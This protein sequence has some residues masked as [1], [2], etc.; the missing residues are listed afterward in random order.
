MKRYPVN[1]DGIAAAV[2]AVLDGQLVIYPTETCYGLGCDA[3]NG[4]AVRNVYRVKQRP[5]SKGLT[6]IVG[7]IEMA[8]DYCELGGTEKALCDAFMPG[9]LTLVAE[10]TAGMP[11][12][13]NQ[14]FVFRV[15][16]SEP[17]RQLAVKADRPIVATSANSSGEPSC[18]S[19]DALPQRLLDAA[20]VVLD[21]G[22]LEERPASTIVEV[23]DG[24]VRV[25][26]RGSIARDEIAKLLNP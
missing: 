6:V 9:P 18:Y 21:G 4:V 10:K 19:V 14:D 2:D 3:T 17:A 16:G 23:V 15:P 20:G 25:H 11:R 7:S 13:L 12:E 1:E 26:R 8:A 5:V 24:G 22:G